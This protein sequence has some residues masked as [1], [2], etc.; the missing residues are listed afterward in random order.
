M[1]A[2]R[3]EVGQ[4]RATRKQIVSRIDALKR[5]IHL[6]NRPSSQYTASGLKRAREEISTDDKPARKSI[7]DIVDLSA[8]ENAVKKPKLSSFVGQVSTDDI[9]TPSVDGSDKAMEVEPASVAADESGSNTAAPSTK[10]S[11]RNDGNRS[12]RLFG[13]LLGHLNKAK[14][15]ITEEQQAEKTLRRVSVEQHVQERIQNDSV[16]IREEKLKQLTEDVE[17]EQA[18]L[19]EAMAKLIYSE[20]K[21]KAV[22]LVDRHNQNAGLIQTKATPLIYW[23]PKLH[24]SKT[25]NM[26]LRS[27]KRTKEAL[28]ETIG[29]LGFTDIDELEKLLKTN[30]KGSDKQERV[31][32]VQ[33]G[34]RE[35]GD[36]ASSDEDDRGDDAIDNE[37]VNQRSDHGGE[38]VEE[39]DS[40]NN[41]GVVVVVDGEAHGSSNLQDE[42]NVVEDEASLDSDS[43]PSQEAA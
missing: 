13:A 1:L 17:R 7:N 40:V 32:S 2:L 30:V 23:K 27:R 31:K 36:D 20:K 6:E 8:S 41:E 10:R 26:L 9:E 14:E 22:R 21:V 38:D 5:Q 34:A 39:S 43:E 19:D 16:Q 12:K 18:A 42:V 29:K 37:N 25:K 35:N 4:L 28:R 11:R 3:A 24:T 15:N 33:K